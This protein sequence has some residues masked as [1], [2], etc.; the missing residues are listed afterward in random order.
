MILRF[1]EILKKALKFAI[2]M[3]FM[4]KEQDPPEKNSFIPYSN[5]DW[6]LSVFLKMIKYNNTEEIQYFAKFYIVAKLHIA[7]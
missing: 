4:E 3:S 2:Q 1:M 6:V 5:K 7:N